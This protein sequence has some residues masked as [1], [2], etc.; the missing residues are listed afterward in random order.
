MHSPPDLVA[1]RKH[2]PDIDGLRGIAS[3]LPSLI[4][5]ALC[6]GLFASAAIYFCSIAYATVRG[7]AFPT[8][9]LIHSASAARWAAQNENIL[10]SAVL[11]FA[12]IGG[13]VRWLAPTDERW[14]T[15]I[16][17][18]SLPAIAIA[19][20]VLCISAMWSG[21]YRYGDQSSWAIGG[22]I[23][24][25]DSANYLSASID[26]AMGLGY[27][28]TPAT[29]RPL[30]AAIRSILLSA[31]G[32][33]LPV[34]LMLQACLMGAAITFATVSVARWRGVWAGIAFFGLTYTYDRS[35][36]QTT[37]TETTGIF[38]ALLSIPYFIAALS[39]KSIKAAYIALALTTVALTV[40]M[41]SMFT[42]PAL[43]IW[44]VWQF[45]NGTKD[46]FRISSIA[47]AIVLA[48]VVVS[49]SLG[50]LYADPRASGMGGNFAYTVCGITMGTDWTGCPSKFAANHP[51]TDSGTV[52]L[53][54]EMAWANFLDRPVVSVWRLA[55][56]VQ[57][58][59]VDLPSVLLSGPTMAPTISAPLKLVISIICASGIVRLIV[60]KEFDARFWT[61]F[62]LA[63][64]ASS[65][66]IYMDAGQRAMAASFPLIALFFA[67]GIG[68]GGPHRTREVSTSAPVA[69]LVTLAVA[70]IVT[71]W[72]IVRPEKTAIG[73]SDE[74][75]V[76]GGSRMTGFLI[77]SNEDNLRKDVPSI[78]IG[79]LKSIVAQ[80]GLERYQGLLQ[81]NAPSV[82]FGFVFAPRL[83]RGSQSGPAFI[84]P[85]EVLLRKDVPAWRFKVIR[86]NNPKPGNEKWYLV[87]SASPA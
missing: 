11:L 22:L 68:S 27:W 42:I 13:A 25:S 7:W 86:W 69:L 81:P 60:R 80:S 53:L 19:S 77:V 70:V 24:F 66:L 36:I 84:V 79:D 14:L 6:L 37:L 49:S 41:G 4:A 48:V 1:I 87:T 85:E 47:A 26:H 74:M 33:S 9:A 57:R 58:F 62:W 31:S 34:M 18:W 59:I 43:I 2:Q 83:E 78:R 3:K 51:L 55:E 44:I 32:Y 76:A 72:A 61:L 5:L 50:H 10:G 56:A 63:M 82:P 45:G 23:Q 35:F 75:I 38:F 64:L 15:R 17:T 73:S 67:M 54:Y 16:F 46:R 20:L 40:R 52:R 28:T 39:Q 71:P 12:C 65:A 21:I 30:A 29:Y 8:T